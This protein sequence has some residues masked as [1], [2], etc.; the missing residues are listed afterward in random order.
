MFF[1]IPSTTAS[2]S[3]ATTT[4][5]AGESW[6]HHCVAGAAAATSTLTATADAV[7][8]PPDSE[9]R[10]AAKLWLLNFSKAAYKYLRLESEA[11]G[12]DPKRL[13]FHDK[14]PKDTELLAKVRR[15][16]NTTNNAGISG[17]C[18]MII[19]ASRSWSRSQRCSGRESS[20]ASED[21]AVLVIAE[22]QGYQS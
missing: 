11:H 1:V 12:V 9:N 10:S 13:V 20:G 7:A 8:A 14:F 16:L 3:A 17:T 6:G 2:N 19:T 21:G 5:G 22:M 18:A 4:T 15:V